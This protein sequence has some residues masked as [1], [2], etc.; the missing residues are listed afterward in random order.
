MH[1]AYLLVTKHSLSHGFQM[2]NDFNPNRMAD[3]HKFSI[4]NALNGTVS[5]I[6]RFLSF[7]F[8]FLKINE[9]PNSN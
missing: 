6:C 2:P 9:K 1:V 5:F 7:R 8:I 3:E 4:N